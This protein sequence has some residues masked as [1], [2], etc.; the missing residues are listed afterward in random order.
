MFQQIDPYV[1]D[2]HYEPLTASE[3]DLAL[4]VHDHMAL[5]SEKD[6][7][8]CLP[9]CRDVKATEWEE[10]FSGKERVR[11]CSPKGKMAWIP[12]SVRQISGVAV[13]CRHGGDPDRRMVRRQQILWQMRRADGTVPD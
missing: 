1:F 8:I 2:N 4:L 3:E 11:D 12:G 13:L 10:V 6:G 5:V 7:G 9:L